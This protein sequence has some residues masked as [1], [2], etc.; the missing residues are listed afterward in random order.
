M[1]LIS[2]T[3]LWREV[4]YLLCCL[5]RWFAE[6]AAEV[7]MHLLKFSRIACLSKFWV[8]IRCIDFHCVSLRLHWW[9]WLSKHKILLFYLLFL[10]LIKAQNILSFLFLDFANIL[11]IL[12]LFLFS[13]S[14]S[15]L[16]FL[17][18][19]KTRSQWRTHSAWLSVWAYEICWC[20]ISESLWIELL[21]LEL[22]DFWDD[23][24]EL[25]RRA[26]LLLVSLNLILI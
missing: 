15:L 2:G 21:D 7:L 14:H 22:L 10:Q 17:D 25:L 11:F 16:V 4:N 6:S 19:Q 26:L 23:L 8:P 12:S 24:F 5:R 9:N 13:N 18:L 20:I 3:F 1:Y